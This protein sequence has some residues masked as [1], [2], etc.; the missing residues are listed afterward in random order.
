MCGAKDKREEKWPRVFLGA[1]SATL[2]LRSRSAESERTR[3][4]G[5]RTK[6]NGIKTATEGKRTLL[7]TG[8]SD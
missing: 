4:L 6:R 8:R 5:E 3:Q 7:E 1:Q 2:Y